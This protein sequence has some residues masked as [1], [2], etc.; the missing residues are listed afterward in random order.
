MVSA[1]RFRARTQA[2]AQIS[3]RCGNLF[4]ISSADIRNS[5]DLQ[6]GV[7]FVFDAAKPFKTGKLSCFLNPDTKELVL[8]RYKPEG[9]IYSG[10]LIA[11][12]QQ[13]GR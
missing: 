5:G 8:N 2:P 7:S 6:K 9:F 12:V 3:N 10:G 11:A 4:V 1:W 13:N